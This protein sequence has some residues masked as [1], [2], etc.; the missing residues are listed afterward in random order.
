MKYKILSPFPV[1]LFIVSGWWQIVSRGSGQTRNLALCKIIFA[2]TKHD[3]F[4]R[5]NMTGISEEENIP[6]RE[7]IRISLWIYFLE[8]S[9]YDPLCHSR[10]SLTVMQRFLSD[11]QHICHV[12]TI[13]T[14]LPQYFHSQ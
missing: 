8:H 10:L 6:G 14:C 13:I 7:K 4:K 12:Q 11:C 1:Y 2:I 5:I 9:F 3:S